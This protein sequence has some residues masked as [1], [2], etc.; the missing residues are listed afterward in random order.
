MCGLLVGFTLA[1]RKS[2]IIVGDGTGIESATLRLG[3]RT[4][5]SITATRTSA[6]RDAR[7]RQNYRR[8]YVYR[9]SICHDTIRDDE[10]LHVG[11]KNWR[12]AKQ[13]SVPREIISTTSQHRRH[14]VEMY[15]SVAAA[16]A[17]TT[18]TTTRKRGN[19]ECIATKRPPDV[20]QSLSALITTPMPSLKSLSLSVAIL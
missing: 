2:L 5:S 7:Y 14:A 6:I 13:L 17:A 9:H 4:R 16:S 8:Y 19:C 18:T 11:L 12:I 3:T 15:A 10:R 1:V 20:A